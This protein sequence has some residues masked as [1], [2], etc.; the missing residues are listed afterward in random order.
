MNK[1]DISWKLIDLFFKD[2]PNIISKHHLDSYNRF[3]D[4]GIVNIFKNQ[5]PIQFNKEYDNE[6]NEFRYQCNMYLVVKMVNLY[7]T[8]N[9][10]FLTKI[11]MVIRIDNI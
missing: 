6:V 3:W 8:E 4:E 5:N 2:N 7:T 1:D 11:T 9:P 10:L